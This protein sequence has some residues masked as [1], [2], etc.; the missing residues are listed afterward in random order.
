MNSQVIERCD[1]ERLR[2]GGTVGVTGMDQAQLDREQADAHVVW[3][4]DEGVVQARCSVWHSEVPE[5]LGKTVGTMGHFAATDGESTGKVLEAA[6]KRLLSAGCDYAV[7]PMDGNTWRNYRF[8]TS[9]DPVAPRFFLEPWNPREWPQ[10]FEQFGW[11]KLARYSSS[12]I[13]LSGAVVNSERSRLRQRLESS[14]VKTRPIDLSRYR[15]ELIAIFDLSVV[16]FAENFLYT[17]LTKEEFLAMYG[18][19]ERLTNPKFVRIAE[20]DGSPIGFVFAIPDA[21]E[22]QATGK[23]ETLIVKTLAVLPEKRFAGL[24]TLLVEEV[25]GAAVEAGFRWAIHALQFESNASLR[26]TKR[27]GALAIR[28]YTLYA[29]DL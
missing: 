25:Q 27:H 14:G 10:W 1:F 22:I 6:E 7:G 20:V 23:A 19:V 24:G 11:N 21:G 28:E 15:E 17:P 12:R 4:G 16:C 13:D 2:L 9:A 5:V 26:I 18:E 8:M 29:K 3:V